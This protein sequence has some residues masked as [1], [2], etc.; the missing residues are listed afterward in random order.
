MYTPYG[1]HRKALSNLDRYSIILL[2]SAV[3][4]WHHVM[5]SAEQRDRKEYDET[6]S[7]A[8]FVPAYNSCNSCLVKPDPVRPVIEY[9]GFPVF[10]I[11]LFSALRCLLVH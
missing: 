3:I 7:W 2:V 11:P 5:E 6:F 9:A 4:G 8:W 1:V 10:A